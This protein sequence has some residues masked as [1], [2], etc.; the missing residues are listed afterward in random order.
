M[1]ALD[2]GALAS[3][4]GIAVGAMIW[5]LS[6]L[7]DIRLKRATPNTV[8]TEYRD[9]QKYLQKIL[10]NEARHMT[11]IKSRRMFQNIQSA[12]EKL[13]DGH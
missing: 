11:P 10:S 1:A 13:S 3:A 6:R 12:M 2:L 9:T 5:I 8:W 7:E 4:I